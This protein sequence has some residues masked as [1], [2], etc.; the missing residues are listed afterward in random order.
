MKGQT[1]IQFKFFHK[2]CF[3]LMLTVALWVRTACRPVGSYQ[4]FRGMYCPTLQFVKRLCQGM[5]CLHL[6]GVISSRDVDFSEASFTTYKLMLCC[7][8]FYCYENLISSTFHFAL[9]EFWLLIGVFVWYIS[10]TIGTSE[11]RCDCR[12]TVVWHQTCYN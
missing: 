6:R 10:E 5:C 4:C 7:N 8:S 9:Q 1:W 2:V 3:F 12:S 11:D